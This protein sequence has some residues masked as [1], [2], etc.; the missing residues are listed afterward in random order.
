M[1]RRILIT[2]LAPF[3]LLSGLSAQGLWHLSGVACKV[4][5]GKTTFFFLDQVGS[6]K[7]AK[8]G[9]LGGYSLSQGPLS[10]DTL[11]SWAQ[12]GDRFSTN[13]NQECIA[14]DSGSVFSTEITTGSG[15]KS[16]FSNDGHWN[17][18]KLFDNG[19]ISS[20][21]D[22]RSASGLGWEFPKTSPEIGSTSIFDSSAEL[23]CQ[24]PGPQGEKYTARGVWKTSVPVKVNIKSRH[25][26]NPVMAYYLE[27]QFIPQ[28]YRRGSA[29]ILSQLEGFPQYVKR[30]FTGRKISILIPG[31]GIIASLSEENSNDERKWKVVVYEY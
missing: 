26:E 29:T 16:R 27:T 1:I 4:D 11:I 17:N 31:T 6:D 3:I 25:Y 19:V 14:G 2:A 24:V 15:E 30:K 20:S 28:N 18:Y 9:W 8:N 7:A 5:S 12:F 13:R 22:L 21:F 10:I 23:S